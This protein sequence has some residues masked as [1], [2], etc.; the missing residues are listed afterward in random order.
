MTFTLQRKTKQIK[1]VYQQNE[2]PE[3]NNNPKNAEPENTINM[4]YFSARKETSFILKE[5]EREEA[6]VHLCYLKLI[7]KLREN[8][9]TFRI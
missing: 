6:K 9:E 1:R 5:K 7:G 8:R 3:K 4:D 2:K